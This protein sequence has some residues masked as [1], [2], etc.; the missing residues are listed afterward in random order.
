MATIYWA[1]LEGQQNLALTIQGTSTPDLSFV[2]PPCKHRSNH[3]KHLKPL[4]LNCF[5]AEPQFKANRCS[6][7]GARIGASPES[8]SEY[9]PISPPH[10]GFCALLL[11][12]S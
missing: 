11:P 4:F 7:Q 6:S 10:T 12:L 3:R 2:F 1:G 5:L 9:H 8:D